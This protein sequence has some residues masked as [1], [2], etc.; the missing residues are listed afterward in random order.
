MQTT[1]QPASAGGADVR[2]T[3]PDCGGD[4]DRDSTHNGLARLYGPWGCVC[5]WSEWGRQRAPG[6]DQWGVL[7]P[8]LAG[9][10][11]GGAEVVCPDCRGQLPLDCICPEP[12]QG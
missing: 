7:W 9:P 1:D 11:K 4:C 5:G 12:D 2:H 10:S 6:V 3:C 8:G